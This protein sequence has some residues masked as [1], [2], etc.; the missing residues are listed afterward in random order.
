MSARPLPAPA[1][2]TTTATTKVPSG[3]DSA[4]GTGEKS[5]GAGEAGGDVVM[6]DVT[7]ET[8]GAGASTGAKTGGGKKKK[9][10]KK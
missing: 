1:S 7:G 5:V 3:V 9:K 10:G 8:A 2:S 6:K 4:A